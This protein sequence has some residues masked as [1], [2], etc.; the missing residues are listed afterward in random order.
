IRTDGVVLNVPSLRALGFDEP[1][2]P[3]LKHFARAVTLTANRIVSQQKRNRKDPLLGKLR[4][5]T[6]GGHQVDR[7]HARLPALDL[8]AVVRGTWF[9]EPEL[10]WN[11]VAAL[12]RVVDRRKIQQTEVDGVVAQAIHELDAFRQIDLR[13]GRLAKL[14]CVVVEDPIRPEASGQLLFAAE[15]SGPIERLARFRE[16]L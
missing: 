1:G 10:F 12:I 4:V 15:Y 14:I 3:L 5:V 7:F 9:E 11:R 2:L 13:P 16:R 6:A 8:H